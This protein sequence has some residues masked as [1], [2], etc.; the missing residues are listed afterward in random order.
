M[1]GTTIT[2]E[3][4]PE[5]VDVVAVPVGGTETVPLVTGISVTVG[6]EIVPVVVDV[7]LPTGISVVV[8]G[9]LVMA[10][11]EEVVVVTGTSV[12]VAFGRDP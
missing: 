5:A 1:E 4:S 2:V 9:T 12:E 7:V 8:V 6:V 10:G 3:L 11:P